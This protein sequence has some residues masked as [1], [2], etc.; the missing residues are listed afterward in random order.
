MKNLS[1]TVSRLEELFDEVNAHLFDGYLIKPVITVSPDK[2]RSSGS[3]YLGWITT[4]KAW[5]NTSNDVADDGYY[6]INICAEHLD[7]PFADTI[8]TL[9]H[10]MAHLYNLQE[11]IKDCSRW[12][13]AYH[14]KYFAK[15]AQKYGL[16][17]KYNKSYGFNETELNKDTARWV[18]EKFSG[19]SFN[20]YRGG[21]KKST[22][23]GKSIEYQQQ[24]S[25]KYVCPCK[26]I[27][28]AT[29]PVYVI[30]GYCDGEF[31]CEL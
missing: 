4:Y 11:G 15:A 17:V 6:E 16:K 21:S 7:R 31:I 23:T 20:L 27:I 12:G 26:T 28:R 8:G 29:K 14:N 30:C 18:A 1:H 22:K 10:E 9:I 13:N 3:R 24:S 25:R 19:E 2:K 5:K